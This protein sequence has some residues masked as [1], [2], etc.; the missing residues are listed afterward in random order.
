MDN[1][2][3]IIFKSIARNVCRL[4]GSTK[5][6]R[7]IRG[8]FRNKSKDFLQSNCHGFT[9]HMLGLDEESPIPK[10]VNYDFM[11]SFL[12][13]YCFK[14]QLNN[15]LIVGFREGDQTLGHTGIIFPTSQG[16]ILI[17]QPDIG[18]HFKLTTLDSYLKENPELKTET[19]IEYYKYFP[20]KMNLSIY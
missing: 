1:L 5:P 19:S 10:Y 9:L 8:L 7:K 17:H 12:S 13:D 11:D 14:S 4:T 2:R 3:K 15:G 20:D 18:R 16:S 6:Y